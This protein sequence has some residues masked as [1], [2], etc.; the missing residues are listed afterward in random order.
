MA[1]RY[2]VDSVLEAILRASEKG[3]NIVGCGDTVL[4][5][6][7]PDGREAHIDLK[8]KSFIVPAKMGNKKPEM[9]DINRAVY[10]RAI[11]AVAESR[12]RT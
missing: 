12:K 10:K 6:R 9:G 8:T 5:L 3:D 11:D 7:L 2:K 4:I 1:P